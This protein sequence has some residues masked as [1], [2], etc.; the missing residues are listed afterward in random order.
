M[1]RVSEKQE[2]LRAGGREDPLVEILNT[3][4][5]QREWRDLVLKS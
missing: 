3:D 1:C 2:Y 5:E 4:H